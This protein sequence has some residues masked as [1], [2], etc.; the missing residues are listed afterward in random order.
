MQACACTYSIG[1]PTPS[2]YLDLSF[3]GTGARAD[4]VGCSCR[5]WGRPFAD[6]KS[7]INRL[8]ARRELSQWNQPGEVVNCFEI[9]QL[10]VFAH[11]ADCCDVLP[12]DFPSNQART[13]MQIPAVAII[14]LRLSQAFR[15]CH[16]TGRELPRAH[17]KE[18][19]EDHAAGA[20]ELLR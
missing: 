15:L 12:W 7:G 10:E 9:G 13:K 2:N 8:W 11:Q 6:A 14:W 17:A 19:S 4:D 3:L 5:S 1:C 16:W 18:T 20:T